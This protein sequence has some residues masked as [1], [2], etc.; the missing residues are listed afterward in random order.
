MT[1][2][3]MATTEQLRARLTG[4]LH[5]PGEAGYDEATTGWNVL[6]THRPA[7]VGVPATTADVTELVRHARAAGLDI[8]VMGTG[9]GPAALVDG[10]MLIRTTKL[11]TVEID[12]NTATAR[13][14]AG[15]KW[16]PV[17]AAAQQHGLAPLLGSTTDVGVVGYVLGGG[18]GWLGRKY[19]MAADSVVSFEVV[20]TDGQTLRVS[21]DENAELFWALRGGGAGSM[22]IVTEVVIDLYPVTTVYG[23][24][25]YYPAEMAA[26]V[27]ARWA[28]WTADV[29]E[30]LTSSV[31]VMNF[32][33]FE[34]VP[35]PLRDQSFVIVR[36]AVADE[37]P[38]GE[39]LLR[40]WR[41]WRTP[42]LDMWGEMPFT[43]AD[44]ISNDP[45]DPLPILLKGMWLD[46]L[47][48]HAIDTLVAGTLP[49]DGPP[50]VLFSEV[51]HA[52]GVIPRNADTAYGNRTQEY[53]LSII[54]LVPESELVPVV[55]AHLETMYADLEPNRA[56][57]YLNFLDGEDRRQAVRQGVSSYERLAAVKAVYDPNDVMSHGLDLTA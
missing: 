17:L 18:F 36:G 35:E 20:T 13:I 6:Y 8:G 44:T 37:T 42:V 47:D 7:L 49:T 14:G 38:V 29:P 46:D 54:A 45:V 22:V 50:L 5:L 2:L 55:K 48:P 12:P 3:D 56:G 23:G 31:A 11:D 43:Q 21:E 16:G 28:A 30:T 51:R 34:D 33:P 19:G 1:A 15:V 25:L 27:M 32:P 9:H 26:E 39:E 53:L 52:G 40:Y 24:N 41:E 57:A 4:D 10:G